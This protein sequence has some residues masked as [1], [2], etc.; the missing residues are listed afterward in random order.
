[1][2][3]LNAKEIKC[4]VLIIFL[5]IVTFSL[6]NIYLSI[7]MQS[8]SSDQFLKMTKI[9]KRLLPQIY[10]LFRENFLI[11]TYILIDLIHSP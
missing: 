9:Q 1:M 7:K 6:E 11:R 4:V 2:Y 3:M 10:P 5:Q 8:A